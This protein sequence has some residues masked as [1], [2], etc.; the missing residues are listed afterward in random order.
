MKGTVLKWMVQS[1]G[2]KSGVVIE[3]VLWSKEEEGHGKKARQCDLRLQVGPLSPSDKDFEAKTDS[4]SGRLAVVVDELRSAQVICVSALYCQ[5][6]KPKRPAHF[7]PPKRMTSRMRSR[8]L[9][10][11]DNFASSRNGEASLWCRLDC[12]IDWSFGRCGAF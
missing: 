7:T 12:E 1:Q 3:R 9:R 2:E 6:D 8:R 4:I 10:F 11:R 5:S